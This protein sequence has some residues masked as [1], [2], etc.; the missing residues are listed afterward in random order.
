MKAI[1][2]QTLMLLAVV[3]LVM[4]TSDKK[5]EIDGPVIGIDLGTTYSCVGIFKNGRVEIIPNELG[6]RITPSTVAFTDEEKLVG[7]AAK[8]QA[9]VNPLRTVYVVKRLIGRN[10][11][12][13][14][15]QRDLKYLSYKVI[16][17]SGKPYVSIETTAGK[18]TLSPEEVSAMVLVKMKEVAEAYLGRDVK[19][20]VVTVPAYFN[21]AQ[22][23]ATKD[24]GV[25]AGL[26]VLRIINE[27]TAA[28]IAYGLDK[29]S[30]EKNIIVFDL[31]GGTFDVSLLTIDNGVFEVVATA[32]DTHLG[33]EDFDQ[34]LTEH[35]VKT[36]KKKNNLDLKKDPRAFQKLKQEVEKA[37]RDLSSVH[38]VKI[39]IE[40]IMDGIDLSETIT[41]ARF[42]ELCGD[43]F[44]KTLKPVQTVLDD[45]GMKKSEI[46]EIVLVGGSTRIP[47]VQ[48]LIKDFFNGKEP[49]RGIN[50]DEAVAYGAAVQGGIMGGEQSEETKDLLLIDVTPLTLGI[51]TVGGVMTKVIPR[52][53]IIPAKKSQVFTTYQDQQTTVS[54]SVFEGERALTKDNHNLGKFDMNGIPPAP[55]GVPQIEVTFEIDENS[56]LTVSANDKG[57]GKKETITITNDKG[58]LTKE[59]I[60]QM[61]ADSEKYAEEDKAIKEKI[62]A[63]NQFE[64]YIYQMKNSVEDKDKLAEKLSE[65]D[66]S[67]IKDALTDASDWLNA[68]SDAEKDEFEDKLKELQSV[69]DPI[70]S[71]VYQGMGG[72]GGA[73]ADDDEEFDDL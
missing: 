35:F 6:N 53:T 4:A 46:D 41:R 12:D 20:A 25:I 21:D 59:E 50:P 40:G 67:S 2:T 1:L 61:I 55:K 24:A 16:N 3:G 71:K 13:K 33:G 70:I 17:K 14:E 60:D 47:K 49:N 58:R 9:S 54:I 45:S 11:D 26:D 28:A 36:F 63:K 7:E 5:K 73:A 32:G 23:Q 10:F 38:Q 27:P 72:Q 68:N 69:C 51:E 52:G 19:Y 48:Q 56:I 44:K 39:T 29:K 37:K 34:R 30:G 22:R 65:E 15:V 31:G 57:T 62:D 42:E 18:K 43:L 66:K 64:N 8:N